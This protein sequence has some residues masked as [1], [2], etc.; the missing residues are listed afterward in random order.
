MNTQQRLAGTR[1]LAAVCATSAI[2]AASGAAQAQADAYPSKSVRV[3]IG[4]SPGGATDI[5]GR[6]VAQKMTEVLGQNVLVENRTG[7]AGSI[8]ATFVSN[9]AADGYTL[10]LVSS[11]YSINPSL[12]AKLP[13]DP[14]KDLVPVTLLAE[15]PFVLVVHPS[16]PVK[17]VKD[18]IALAKA[19]PGTLNYGSGGIGSSGHLAG[20]LFESLAG[21]D[22]L[23]VPYKGAAPAQ[24]DIVAGQIHLM[25][26]SVISTIPQMKAQRL[27]GL[28]VTSLKRSSALPHLPAMSDAGV[29]GYSTGSWYALL[30]PKGTPAAV[31]ERISAAAA[32]AVAA[33]ELRKRLLA[34]GAEPLGS[35][36]AEFGR[37]L[38][39]EI[40]KWQKVV[41]R[42]GVKAR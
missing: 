18:L 1:A 20:A 29:P 5:V 30:A 11:S 36:P 35:S 41:K 32:K 37:F 21:V 7:A 25:F 10:L 8:A 6:A 9:S 16:M 34:D 19:K 3:V 23:H 14:Q 4:Q 31:V 12:Y 17:S 15:A 27:R 13:Y 2:L 28:A 40:A 24:V 38:G 39:E 22:L 26:A 33:P 42:A